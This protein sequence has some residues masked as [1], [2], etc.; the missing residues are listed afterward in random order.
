MISTIEQRQREFKFTNEFMSRI[1]AED[2]SEEDLIVF[3]GDMN[4]D[5]NIH[6]PLKQRTYEDKIFKNDRE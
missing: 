5:G 1:L 6:H 4:V 2:V 3:T